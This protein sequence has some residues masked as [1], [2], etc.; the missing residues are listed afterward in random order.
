MSDHHRTL[1]GPRA[2]EL[3]PGTWSGSHGWSPQSTGPMIES[4]NPDHGEWLA[5]V[6]GATAA[7]YE[8]VLAAAVEA[9]RSN[10]AGC[11]RRSAAR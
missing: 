5:R 9:A 11:R 2:R 3:N 10:G 4:L 6:R 7:D 8:H 1:A